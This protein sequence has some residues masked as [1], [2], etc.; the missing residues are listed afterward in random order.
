MAPARV[1]DGP[2]SKSLP[3][4]VGQ[5]HYAYGLFCASHPVAFLLF[6]SSVVMVCCYPLLNLPLPGNVPQHYASFS[7]NESR[8]DGAPVWFSGSPVCYVQQVILKTAVS[9]WNDNLVLTD[10]FRGPLSEVFKLLE[11]IRNYELENRSRSLSHVCLHVEA[12]KS[13]YTSDRKHI[14]PEYSCLVLSPANLWHQDFQ[15]FQQDASL[16]STIFNYVSLQ[17]SKISLAEI[18][19]GL[20]MKD[21]G[22]KRYPL[23]T[24]QRTLQYAVTLMLEENDEAYIDGLRKRLS[25]L[26]PLHQ[27]SIVE[28]ENGPELHVFYPGDFH[29]RQLI[30][31]VSLYLSFFLYIYFSLRKVE[32]VKAK[33]G[34][35]LFAVLTLIASLAMSTGLCCFFGH[36]LTFSW[37]ELYP[38]LAMVVGVENV[39][40]LS[41][42]VY[43]T[44]RDLD[45]KIRIAQGLSKEG[46]SITYNLMT[47]VT[48]LTVGLFTFVPAIQRFCIFAVVGL[49]SD[50]FMQMTFYVSTLSIFSNPVDTGK[51][52][53][54]AMQTSSQGMPAGSILRS[55]SHPRL[56]GLVSQST[57]RFPTI[58]VAPVHYAGKVL[59]KIPRRI[60]IVH[61]WARTRIVQ[62][63]LMVFMI[64]WIVFIAY[65][66]DAIENFF[67]MDTAE[68]EWEK[69][70]GSS[71][72]Q[73]EQTSQHF[74]A[75][76][77]PVLDHHNVSYGHA[78]EDIARLRPNRYDPWD[79]LSPYHWSTILSL[80]NISISGRYLSVLPAIRLSHVIAPQNALHLRNP[81]ER[82]AQHFHWQTLAAALDPL[83]FSDGDQRSQGSSLDTTRGRKVTE[84]PLLPSSP[85][86]LFFLSLLCVVSVVVLA[87]FMVLL[88]RCVCTRN[89]AEWRSAWVPDPES[90]VTDSS[91]EVVLEAIPLVLEGHPQEV[92]CIASDG[93]IVASTCLAGQL[94]A[95]DAISGETLAT[96]NRK[97]FF[98]LRASQ[99]KDLEES[100]TPSFET[101]SPFFHPKESENPTHQC[102]NRFRSGKA[103]GLTGRK[104]GD[105]SFPDL[106]SSINTNFASLASSPHSPSPDDSKS[107]YDFGSKYRELFQ[108]HRLSCDLSGSS[109][110]SE[111]VSGDC[112][113]GSV[114]SSSATPNSFLSPRLS[115]DEFPIR[116]SSVEDPIPVAVPPIWCIDCRE[117]IVVLGCADGRLEFWEGASG[118][119]KCLYE[120]P[121]SS[122]VTAVKLVGNRVVAAR[123]SGFLDFLVLE[124]Y[125]RGRPIDWGFTA[126]R[127]THV[128]SGSTGSLDWDAMVSRGEEEDI[129]CVRLHSTRAHQQ[130]ITVLQTEGGR[131][132]TGSQDHTLKVFRLEDHLPLYTLHGHCGPITCL[133][134]DCISPMTAG[135]GSQDGL[136]CVWDLLTGA[137]MYSIQAHDGAVLS[138]TYS[139]SYVIS[140]GADDRLCV[141][142]RFQGHLL[143]TIQMVGQPLIG[144][145]SSIFIKT[146]AYCSSIAMLTHSLLVTS[147]QG[148]LIVWDVRAGDPV[149]V[150]RLGHSDSCVFVKQ[151]LQLRDS[152][153]CDYA[154][155][156]RI[157]RFPL[158][159]DKT[160]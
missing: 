159:T 104:S 145:V 124:S 6:A 2:A 134:I 70:A 36:M 133:F 71:G 96:V 1:R 131:V 29:W 11:N 34:M 116:R 21:T 75:T 113:C 112:S 39:F 153:V 147:K 30:P 40:V 129:R 15:E 152:V 89:Y 64:S 78:E 25:S 160:E 5:L 82:A 42:A 93:S 63:S 32:A 117:N 31:L 85:M 100:F 118:R 130:P 109:L 19:F 155:Q 37:R 84:L 101:G 26:Y 8:T 58:V 74:L 98:A 136:L 146:Q 119:F 157:V 41:K 59:E 149:R 23:R 3:E 68:R 132:L 111:D 154:N 144:K 99:N 151:L 61:F 9:P 94:I 57:D 66:S 60:R 44:P 137:C 126:Y 50:Y 62:R 27:D 35:S 65:S 12:V 107:G 125:S 52:C 56:N 49:L 79:R 92:E 135:S 4:R 120:N 43:H 72:W 33:C 81:N 48:I 83:D 18:S 22:V 45:V 158:A 110:D 55:K 106:R 90:I 114:N 86:E 80:Y 95:W 28:S 46:W 69:A 13:R 17:R 138:L 47:E 128:R 139:A 87:Y 156:L 121:N 76:S 20:R 67:L 140:L 97:R 24:R 10:A 77:A 115:V 105:L 103:N 108:M 142:E 127:R 53:H 54:N 7:S 102:Y 73:F 122:G 123:L 148:S 14:L 16:L 143:N 91:T 51:Y 141:W 150:V 88:Y 38:Y